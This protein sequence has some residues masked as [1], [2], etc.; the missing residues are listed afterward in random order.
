VAVG[1]EEGGKAGGGVDGVVVGE[2]GCGEVQVPV[3]LEGGGE[4]ADGGGDDFVGVLGLAVGLGVVGGGHVEFGAGLGGERGPYVRGKTGVP[5]RD[6]LRG[7]TVVAVN[8]LVE[9]GCDARGVDGLGGGFDDDALGEAIG[10]AHEGI[11][12]AGGEGEVHDEIH[13]NGLPGVLGDG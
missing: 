9:E 8:G 11:V 7:P 10:K 12:A 4:V 5:V 1:E 3:V 13:A 2:L 6:H